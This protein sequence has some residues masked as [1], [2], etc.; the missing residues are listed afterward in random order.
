[1][2][3][4]GDNL[5][6]SLYAP[7]F[8]FSATLQEILV[9]LDLFSPKWITSFRQTALA[10]KPWIL[11]IFPYSKF[12]T[13]Q[14]TDWKVIAKKLTFC[15]LKV[16]FLA[17]TFQSVNRLI[18]NFE[19][20]KICRIRGLFAK[21]VSQKQVIHFGDIYPLDRESSVRQE[22]VDSMLLSSTTYQSL[23]AIA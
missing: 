3:N 17:I 9:Q 12:E 13:N 11:Q 2:A 14:L 23:I 7:P 22:R 1:M 18:S 6:C 8:D 21:A 16:N 19:N 20:W 15:W 10:N 4:L 5:L